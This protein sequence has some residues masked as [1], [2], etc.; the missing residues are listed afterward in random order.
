MPNRKAK[1]RKMARKKRHLDIR[2]WE[3]QQKIKRKEFLKK[4]RE[5]SEDTSKKHTEGSHE[6]HSI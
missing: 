2:K 6:K 5:S 4:L 1:A 3:R